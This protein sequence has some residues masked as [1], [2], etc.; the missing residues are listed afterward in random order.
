MSLPPLLVERHR[1]AI[2]FIRVLSFPVASATGALPVGVKIMD[3][4]Q[5]LNQNVET[6]QKVIKM[7]G[8]VRVKKASKTAG[9][10]RRKMSA[11]GRKRIA[12]A[13]RARWAKIRA[14]KK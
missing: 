5:I 13:Q 4:L 1:Q 8:G 14:A 10:P 9:K 12:A 11:A 2:P 6:M 7:L 3:V